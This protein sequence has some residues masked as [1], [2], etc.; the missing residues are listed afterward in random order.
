M[1]VAC[2][3]LIANLTEF[4]YFVVAVFY[5]LMTLVFTGLL[6]YLPLQLILIQNRMLFYFLGEESHKAA[7]IPHVV[8][9]LFRSVNATG[10]F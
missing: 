9:G 3:T 7:V 10:E 1:S 8:F 5:L 4:K 2:P 6:K